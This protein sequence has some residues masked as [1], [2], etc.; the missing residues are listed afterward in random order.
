MVLKKGG[1]TLIINKKN[2][3][4]PTRTVTRWRVCIDYIKLNTATINYHYPFHFIDQMLDRLV[5]HCHL[6]FLDGYSGYN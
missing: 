4:I 3:L 5:R 1:F 2:G 6:Y